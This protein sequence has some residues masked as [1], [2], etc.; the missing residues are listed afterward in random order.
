[1]GFQSCILANMSICPSSSGDSFSVL[2]YNP[3]ARTQSQYVQIPVQDGTW[4]VVGP[5]SKTIE[6]TLTDPIANFDFVAKDL[7]ETLL[8]KVLFFK[9][10]NLPPL[11]YNVYSLKR[12]SSKTKK[13]KPARTVKALEQIGFRDNYINFDD[14]GKLKSM[15]IKNYTIDVSQN[16]LYY[17]SGDGSQAWIF[18]PNPDQQNALP[19]VDSPES[20]F[21]T[22]EGNLVREVK[23]DFGDWVTQII[24]IYPDTD[25]IEFDYLIGPVDLR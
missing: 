1:M 12:T 19:I 21:H 14:E 2:I 5:D 6:S 9:A 22:S 23:Q 10:E 18:R 16:M 15:T 8:P 17:E 20:T 7:G 4:E 24:R 3:I 25:Y 11:G 13:S